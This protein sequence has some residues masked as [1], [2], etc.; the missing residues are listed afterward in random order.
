MQSEKE[1]GEVAFCVE[2]YMKEFD[3]SKEEAKQELWKLVKSA[4]KDINREWLNENSIPLAI[5][6]R[7]LNLARVIDLLYREEDGYTNSRTNSKELITIL[8]VDPIV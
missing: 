7:I 1:R 5:L 6:E 8:L 3:V 4:W 2:C